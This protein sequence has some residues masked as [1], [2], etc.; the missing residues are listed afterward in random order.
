MRERQLQRQHVTTTHTI[1]RSIGQNPNQICMNALNFC[2]V[3]SLNSSRSPKTEFS[4]GPIHCHSRMHIVGDLT[5]KFQFDNCTQWVKRHLQSGC[6]R[7]RSRMLE[8]AGFFLTQT[9]KSMLPS[10]QSTL[11]SS[12]V[13]DTL[14]HVILGLPCHAMAVRIVIAL[15]Q[16]A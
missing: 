2:L 13:I 10:R 11:S 12:R 5:F 7:M 4:Q 1:G 6:Q 8:G 14:A 9:S 15:A 3:I 16:P